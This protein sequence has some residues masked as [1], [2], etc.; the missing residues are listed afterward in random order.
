MKIEYQL[1]SFIVVLTHFVDKGYLESL[2]TIEEKY[3]DKILVEYIINKY[4]AIEDLPIFKNININDLEEIYN[5]VYISENEIKNQG[6]ENNGLLY[7]INVASDEL[8]NIIFENNCT[9]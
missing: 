1:R 8:Q 9:M 3:D 6:I 2:Q 4:S 5:N 7:L